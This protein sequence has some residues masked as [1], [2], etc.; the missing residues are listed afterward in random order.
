MGIESI[1]FSRLPDR[2]EEA[3][4]EFM[5]LLDNGYHEDKEN[6]RD[7]NSDVNGNYVGSYEPERSYVTIAL[8]FLDEYEIDAGVTDISDLNDDLILH[9]RK[10]RSKLQYVNT[11]YKIR[12][13]TGGYTATATEVSIDADYK[14]EI[15]EH[16]TSIRK[17]VNQNVADENKKDRIFLKISGLQSEVDR[18]RTT[19][20][21]VA[22]RIIDLCDVIG[23]S[24][25]NLDPAISRIEKIKKIFWDNTKRVDKLP[26]QDRP[27]MLEYDSGDQTEP[28]DD[29][30][31]PF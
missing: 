27:K 23:K 13:T 20:D 22:G 12:S 5:R 8:A 21:A 3:F 19:L 2:T 30:E 25:E 15:S 10:F 6:D 29:D 14:I 28:Q 1:D 4:S 17:I 31:I 9:F 7:Y 11:R 26:K 24:A 18:N 16:L